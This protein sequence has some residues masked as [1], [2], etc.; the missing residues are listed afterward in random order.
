MATLT[1]FLV[2]LAI[3]AFI[4]ALSFGVVAQAEALARL[5]GEPYGTL[6]LSLSVAFIEVALI[7]AVMLGPGN[8]AVIG[9]DSIMAVTMIIMNLVAGAAILVAVRGGKTLRANRTGVA[10]YLG[11]LLVTLSLTFVLPT[12]IAPDTVLSTALQV[13]LAVTIALIYVFFLY[14]QIGPDHRDYQEVEGSKAAMGPNAPIQAVLRTSGREVVWRSTVLVALMVG[15]VIASHF[16]A[17]YMD[18][19]LARVGAPPAVAGLIIATVVFLPETITTIRAAHLQ[20]IQRVS[21]LCH[22]AL[23]S[24]M[25][26]SV[27]AIIFLGLLTHQSVIF[28]ESPVN[29]MFLAVTLALTYLSYGAKKISAPLGLAHL[30]LFAVFIATLAA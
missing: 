9:R 13:L 26:I 15:V 1:V 22:G 25:G 14:R 30:A 7:A 27:P 10:T 20:Q 3:I 28:A 2:L 11:L 21:N 8:H 24:T 16:M 6:I 5:L 12:L 18:L 23:L 17:D 4:S 29:I 19:A